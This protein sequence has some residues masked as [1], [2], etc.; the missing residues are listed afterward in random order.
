MS[1]SRKAG[2]MALAFF[3]LT[4][5][6]AATARADIVVYMG[7]NNQGTDN[8][9][10]DSLTNVN[11]VTG[12]INGTTGVEFV[13]NSGNLSS[14]PSG[15]AVVSPGNTNT[16]FTDIGFSLAN[17]GTFTRAV[18]NIN[19]AYTGDMLVTITGIN[20]D[21]GTYTETF[22]IVANGQNF[23]TF[24]SINGQLML[25]ITLTAQGAGNVFEDLRQVRI[26]EAVGPTEP[27]PEPVTMILFGTGLAGIAAKVRRRRKAAK[28]D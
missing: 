15:Q 21:G 19:S 26:G 18:F 28:L 14:N 20:L 5:A 24:D 11:T 16:A 6:G 13:S 2:L 7:V 17:G 22:A 1:H 9:L 4:F 23:F 8:V 10:L 25:S 12:T 27:V 3:A